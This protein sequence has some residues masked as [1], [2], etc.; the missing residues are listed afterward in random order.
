MYVVD[1][2]DEVV[3]R[4]DLPRFDVGAPCP[5]VFAGD[6]LLVIA[7]YLS[8]DDRTLRVRFARPRAHFF[9][10]PND[11]AFSGHPLA[12][13]GLEPF[14][15]FEV[16]NSSCV[17]QLEKMNRVHPHHHP[18]LYADL[19]HFVFTFKER[20]FECVAHDM[21]FEK[22]EGSVADALRP[23]CTDTYE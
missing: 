1:D 19:R 11:E 21:Q 9:G 6:H 16:R 3:E 4:T 7:Y 22:T 5:F 20:T 10:P 14:G 17:R 12:E 8:A 23:L 18:D 15:V 13:R 2:L